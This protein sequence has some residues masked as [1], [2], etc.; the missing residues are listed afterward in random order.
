MN[1]DID[2]IEWP[3]INGQPSPKSSRHGHRGFL[4]VRRL[5]GMGLVT[6]WLEGRL[7]VGMFHKNASPIPNRGM[8]CSISSL[9]GNTSQSSGPNL[10][11]SLFSTNHSQDNQP[12]QEDATSEVAEQSWPISATPHS[13]GAVLS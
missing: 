10:H 13:K 12:S 1:E 9:T 4:T 11:V 3:N 5:C 2:Q 6:E 7:E 8:E